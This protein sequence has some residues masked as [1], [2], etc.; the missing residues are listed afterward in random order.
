[1]ERARHKQMLVHGLSHLLSMM[2]FSDW[3]GHFR[4]WNGTA[5]HGMKWEKIFSANEAFAAKVPP[6]VPL[7]SFA[8]PRS[9]TITIL[10]QS[11]S[12]YT[13]RD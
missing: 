11:I 9:F 6:A 13:S 4:G 8:P 2:N 12:L 3:L 7:C 1:L 10:F 5:E